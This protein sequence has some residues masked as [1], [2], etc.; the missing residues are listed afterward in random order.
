[1]KKRAILLVNPQKGHARKLGNEILKEFL[2]MNIE[3]DI[4]SIKE[5][6]VISHEKKYN[7]SIVL[8]GDGT[9]LSAARAVSPFGIPIFPI[10]LGTFGFIAEVQPLEW[11]AVFDRWM[12]GK[13]SVS[14][15]LMLDV[16]VKRDGRKIFQK[17]CL[18]DV[19]ISSSGIAKIINLRLFSSEE[20]TET[21][22][23]LG[24]YRSDGLIVATPTG[25]TAYSAAAGGPVVDPELEA[26]IISPICPFMLTNRP[27]VLP[28]SGTVIA[29]VADEQ[30]SEVILTLDGQVKER[31]KKGDRILIEK[32]PYSCFLIASSRSG[33]YAALRKK[34]SWAGEGEN[35]GRVHGSEGKSVI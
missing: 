10:N 24:S 6:P 13:E 9:V 2:S 12:A 16:S 8:G 7:V 19:I 4:Y 18:N 3:A 33:F 5:K 15:R 29:E 23:N 31:L 25:S 22:L 20:G 27:L 35:Q 26:L 34:L 1:M 28:A 30:Q 21:D 11:R 17:C 14:R 32:A